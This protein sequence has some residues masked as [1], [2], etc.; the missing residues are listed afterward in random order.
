MTNTQTGSI[1][2][3]AGLVVTVAS[4]FGF[5]INQSELVTAFA[6]L[7][8]LYGIVHQLVVTKKVVKAAR[9]GGVQL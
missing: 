2:A 9:A 6:G 5:V 4:H 7:I 3:V 1:V 8:A